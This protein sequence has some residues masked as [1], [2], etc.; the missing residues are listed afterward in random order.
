MSSCPDVLGLIDAVE[1]S[2]NVWVDSPG[3][4]RGRSVPQHRLGSVNPVASL[5]DESSLLG[6]GDR[7]RYA[8][9]LRLPHPVRLPCG[10][11]VRR[12][13]QGEVFANISAPFHQPNK[14]GRTHGLLPLDLMKAPQ[15]GHRVESIHAARQDRTQDGLDRKSV[16]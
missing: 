3:K 1:S 16:V 9:R 12:I 15:R 13:N 5:A 11:L 2:N 4:L 7:V 8:R 10:A 6:F 14:E